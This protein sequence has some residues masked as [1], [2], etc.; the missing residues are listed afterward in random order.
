MLEGV[1]SRNKSDKGLPCVMKTTIYSVIP[2][3]AG[4]MIVKGS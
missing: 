1:V 3:K 2:D 4:R